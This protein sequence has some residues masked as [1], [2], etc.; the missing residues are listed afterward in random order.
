M[1]KVQI[2]YLKSGSKEISGFCKRAACPFIDYKSDF[3]C[4]IRFLREVWPKQE[5]TKK[6]LRAQSL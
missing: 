5:S 4:A 1:L 2:S 6:Y 3:N